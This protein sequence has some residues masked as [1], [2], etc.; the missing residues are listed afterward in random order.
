MKF[1]SHR[2][3]ISLESDT[4]RRYVWALSSGSSL[5]DVYCH[6]VVV[7]WR[8]LWSRILRSKWCLV[9]YNGAITAQHYP[10]WCLHTPLHNSLHWARYYIIK[11]TY[12][13]IILNWIYPT[14]LR[15]NSPLIRRGLT[16]WIGHTSGMKAIVGYAF[17]IQNLHSADR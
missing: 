11:P 17:A 8:A 16:H 3:V 15:T 4:L 12:S 6:W 13:N 7:D 10:S 2:G 14:L 5:S 1:H 9:I